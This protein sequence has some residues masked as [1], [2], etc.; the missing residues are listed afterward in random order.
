MSTKHIIRDNCASEIVDFASRNKH[1]GIDYSIRKRHYGCRV[2]LTIKP[3]GT[4]KKVCKIAF[5]IADQHD[6]MYMK[7][8]LTIFENSDFHPYKCS[9][10]SS[11]ASTICLSD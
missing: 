7:S 6:F 4:H 2:F 8:F 11:E 1:I 9:S 5:R 3:T 10:T